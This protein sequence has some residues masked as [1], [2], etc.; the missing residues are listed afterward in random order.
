MKKRLSVVLTGNIGSGKTLVSSVFSSLGVPIFN[1]DDEAKKLY[2]NKEIIAAILQKFGSSVV[3]DK[4]EIDF[5][6]LA[7]HVF[8]DKEKLRFVNSI[9]H[10]LVIKE[11]AEWSK[12]Q[13]FPYHI[14]ESAI[15]LEQG[16]AHNFD[17]IIMVSAP[18]DIRLRRV[19][20]RDNC[21]ADQVRLRMSRQWT[22]NRKASIADFIIKNDD[23]ELVIPQIFS[24]H[25]KLLALSTQ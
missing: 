11:F 19:M 8:T 14:I 4:H 23:S 6:K 3:N 24:V 20:L 15:I 25:K 1:A 2:S 16:P 9:I 7:G 5:V 22:E 12:K 17:F 10:P 21:S 13:D 18:E